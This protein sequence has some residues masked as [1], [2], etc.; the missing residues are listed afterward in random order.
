MGRRIKPRRGGRLIPKMQYWERERQRERT[1][2]RRRKKRR[3]KN[4]PHEEGRRRK[5]ER[6]GVEGKG[7]G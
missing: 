5:G 6:S 2:G 4:E 7:E 1:S 3:R